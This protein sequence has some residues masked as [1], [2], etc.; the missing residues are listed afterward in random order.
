MNQ[1]HFEEYIANMPPEL[2]AEFENHFLEHG[3]SVNLDRTID[4]RLVELRRLVELDHNKNL[5]A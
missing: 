3:M 2:H 4:E 5:G 1:G